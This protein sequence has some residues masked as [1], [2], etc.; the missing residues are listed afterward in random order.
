MDTLRDFLRT[1]TRAAHDR[2]DAAFGAF[3]LGVRAE[4]VA[5]LQAH[6]AALSSLP[7]LTPCGLPPV[8]QCPLL[9]TDLRDLGAAPPTGLP[10]LRF[11]GTAEAQA[12][13]A[14]YVVVGSRLGARLLA[15][16]LRRCG[17]P[18]ARAAR[19]LTDQSA[20]P[21]W[22]ALRARL[23]GPDPLPR[24]DVLRGALR[25]FGRFETAASTRVIAA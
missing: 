4:Y 8:D 7:P 16:R 9:E 19:Y 14:Y 2:V 21:A 23:S 1:R 17:A 22:A 3:D 6:H 24:A 13:G 20:A 15:D 5:F 12:L 10:P 18:H 25:T 11:D